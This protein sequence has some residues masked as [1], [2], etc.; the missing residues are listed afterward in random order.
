MSIVSIDRRTLKSFEDNNIT[1][2]SYLGMSLYSDKAILKIC[3][4]D[5][6]AAVV[7]S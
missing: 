5:R 6:P 4:F 3:V 7:G 2:V 1:P